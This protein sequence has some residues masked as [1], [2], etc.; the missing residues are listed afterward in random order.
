MIKKVI[1]FIKGF[2]KIDYEVKLADE[3]KPFLDSI[4]INSFMNLLTNIPITNVEFGVTEYHIEKIDDAPDEILNEIEKMRKCQ[5]F[6]KVCMEFVRSTKQKYFYIFNYIYVQGIDGKLWM[7]TINGFLKGLITN[8]EFDSF[9][10]NAL[11]TYLNST[12][13]N[14]EINKVLKSECRISFIEDRSRVYNRIIEGATIFDSSNVLWTN[15]V[16]SEK[17]IKAYSDIGIYELLGIE[18]ICPHIEWNDINDE[19]KM[20]YD[21]HD[22]FLLSPLMLKDEI[23]NIGE[24]KTMTVSV[25]RKTQSVL[26]GKYGLYNKEGE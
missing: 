18:R 13:I 24:E 21:F 9:I 14:A 16:L 20:R 11:I 6:T 10:V 5:S 15:G 17:Y 22:Q 12:L 19:K 25:R 7:I 3:P 2:F 1:K 4:A 23:K 8:N 26:S